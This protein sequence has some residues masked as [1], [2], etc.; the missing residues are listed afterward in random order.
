LSIS[1]LGKKIKRPKVDRNFNMNF[2]VLIDEWCYAKS[3]S[4]N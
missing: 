1:T 4:R 2:P 3:T